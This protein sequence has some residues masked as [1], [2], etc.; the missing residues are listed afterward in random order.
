[1]YNTILKII[2]RGIVRNIHVLNVHV[3]S[4]LLLKLLHLDLYM[5]V[6]ILGIKLIHRLFTFG[7]SLF[8]HFFFFLKLID[9]S[10]IF[11]RHFS[12]GSSSFVFT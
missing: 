10:A 6:L 12:L 4:I 2:R 8:F 5:Q 7:E 3:A 9:Q 1:M 11:T